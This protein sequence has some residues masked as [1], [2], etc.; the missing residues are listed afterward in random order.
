VFNGSAHDKHGADGQSHLHDH[1]HEASGVPALDLM[2]ELNGEW[3]AKQETNGIKDRNS[4]GNT[5]F[6]S[7][8]MRLSLNQWSGFVSVGVPIVDDLNGIQSE[9]SWRI[10]T[11]AAWAF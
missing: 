1:A 4:G 7:P 2:L 10:T 5:L 9:S 6:I 3:S 11:G 8:G